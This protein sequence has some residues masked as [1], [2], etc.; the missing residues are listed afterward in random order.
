MIKDFQNLSYSIKKT[1]LGPQIYQETEEL[2]RDLFKVLFGEKFIEEI[3]EKIHKLID[4][5]TFL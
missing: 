4:R 2:L 3:T 5:H 1:K